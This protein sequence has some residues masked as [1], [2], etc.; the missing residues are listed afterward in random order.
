MMKRKTLYTLF[1]EPHSRYFLP[2][3]DVLALITLISIAGVVLST[4]DSLAEYQPYF[5]TIEFTTV[6]IFTLEYFAR[7]YAHGKNWR[8]YVTSFYGV[9]DLLAI[10]PTYLGL[11]SLTFLKAARI[12]RV[13]QL[14]RAFRIL[15]VTHLAD[16]GL[17]EEPQ[18]ARLYRLTIQIYF[19]SLFS[20][21]LVFGTLIH[22]FEPNIPAFSN[23]PLSMLWAT[24]PL[25]GGV[26]QTEPATIAGNIVV[27]LTRFTGLMLFGLL[28]NLVG[29]SLNRLLLGKR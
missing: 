1:Y 22:F 4:V 15:K 6:S 11:T 3:N 23:I 19:F 29:T 16:L 13:L 20:A 2:F 9:I 18:D 24:K 10:A 21:M 25:M 8:Q 14:L 27:A 12:F 28:I 5:T 7:I 17:D 26:A